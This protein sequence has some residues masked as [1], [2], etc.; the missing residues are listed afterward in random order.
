[1]LAYFPTPYPDE[2]LLSVLARLADTMQYPRPSD[3]SRAIY[4]KDVKSIAADLPNRLDDLVTALPSGHTLTVDQLI[5]EHTLYPFYQP[6]LPEKRAKK[7]RKLM[8]GNKIRTGIYS[9]IAIFSQLG[10]MPKF[11]R[12]CPECVQEDRRLYGQCYW[13]RL[14]QVPGVYICPDHQTT[15]QWGHWGCNQSAQKPVHSARG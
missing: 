1:M 12:F 11:L 3:L 10:P 9:S 5:D 2:L 7:V 4:G 6:F 8:R 14:H 13:H 15:L